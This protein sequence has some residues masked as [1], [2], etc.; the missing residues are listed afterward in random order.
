MSRR[1]QAPLLIDDLQ[2]GV[3]VRVVQHQKALGILHRVA[4]LLEHGDAEAV[5]G[6]DVA[7][8]VVAGQADGCAGASQRPTCW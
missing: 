8:V 6:V 7:R 5:E 2:H 4:V 1:R 3:D